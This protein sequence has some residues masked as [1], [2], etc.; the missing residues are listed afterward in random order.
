MHSGS[1]H[2]DNNNSRLWTFVA[3]AEAWNIE[4]FVVESLCKGMQKTR[5][6][7]A[8]VKV[9]SLARADACSALAP[10]GLPARVSL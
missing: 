1:K 10:S 2:S 5:S 6:R 3:T 8:F 4:V 9:F 7:A